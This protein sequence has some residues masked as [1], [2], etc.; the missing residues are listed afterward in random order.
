MKIRQIHSKASDDDVFSKE[1]ENSDSKFY[2]FGSEHFHN[3]LDFKM[4][5]S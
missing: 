3:K 2:R 4:T 5:P 1:V